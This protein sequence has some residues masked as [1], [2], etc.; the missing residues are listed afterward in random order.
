[1]VLF[2]FRLVDWAFQ[3]T[4]RYTHA[5]K[6]RFSRTS[7]PPKTNKKIQP[8][9]LSKPARKLM[10][11]STR[12]I[13][14][15]CKKKTPFKSWKPLANNTLNTFYCCKSGETTATPTKIENTVKWTQTEKKKHIWVKKTTIPW[16]LEFTLGPQPW[17]RTRTRK[18]AKV[19]LGS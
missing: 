9:F 4:S 6:D 15:F 1:M 7:W 3:F 8:F 18:T 19:A 5:D 11:S 14:R 17:T 16:G 10:Q 2:C 13:K 12:V